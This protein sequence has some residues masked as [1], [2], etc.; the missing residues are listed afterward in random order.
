MVTFTFKYNDGAEHVFDHIETAEYGDGQRIE[1][2]ELLTH[3]FPIGYDFHLCSDDCN[4]TVSGSNL[5]YIEV[6]SE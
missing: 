3:W 4:F 6:E 1:G 5:T 2:N